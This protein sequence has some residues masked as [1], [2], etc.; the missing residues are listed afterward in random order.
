M[1]SKRISQRCEEIFFASVENLQFNADGVSL[2]ELFRDDWIR[3]LIVREEGTSE[4]FSLEIEFSTP[5]IELDSKTLL[6]QAIEYLK[7]MQK[8]ETLGFSLELVDQDWLW[9]AH[10][11]F[12]KLP[13]PDFFEDLVPKVV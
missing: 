9:S 5:S 10:R 4:C 6:S 8:L 3:I 7:Y 12:S 13:D 1:N 11:Q 2:T